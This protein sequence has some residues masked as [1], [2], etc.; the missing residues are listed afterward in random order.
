METQPAPASRK[1]EYIGVDP[2]FEFR[3]RINI[4]PTQNIP[5]LQSPKQL[6][7]MKWGIVPSWAKE[8]STALINARS[9]SVREK[10]TFKSSFY[11]DDV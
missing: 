3:P 4:A 5:V 2:F 10:R 8:S 7:E 9:E 6:V 11:N 1:A